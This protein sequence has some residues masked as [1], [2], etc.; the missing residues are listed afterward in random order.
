MGTIEALPC[1]HWGQGI[2]RGSAA[3]DRR[4][5]G[6]GEGVSHVAAR[7][8]GTSGDLRRQE[9]DLEKMGVPAEVRI[10]HGL[11]VDQVF[12]EAREQSY[13]LIVTGSSQARGMVRHYI[14]RS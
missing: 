6:R 13:D 7:D 12:A 1:L 9:Q 4:T 2:H 5:R 10:R 3:I 14:M 11:V 8:G